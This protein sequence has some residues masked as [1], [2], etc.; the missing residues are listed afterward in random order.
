ME[1]SQRYAW[2]AIQFTAS[3]RHRASPR[4]AA[5]RVDAVR[6]F[7]GFRS[8]DRIDLSGVLIRHLVAPSALP[9]GAFVFTEGPPE[10]AAGRS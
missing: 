1:V 6:G 4:R 3:L 5:R 9:D 2:F 10:A 7:S 8:A